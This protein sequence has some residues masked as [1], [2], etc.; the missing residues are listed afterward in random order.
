MSNLSQNE[1]KEALKQALKEWLDDKFA[2][3]GRWT[4]GAFLAA[5]IGAIVMFILHMNGWREVV[6]AVRP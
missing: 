1:M 3:F 4:M 5:L 2:E 6:K